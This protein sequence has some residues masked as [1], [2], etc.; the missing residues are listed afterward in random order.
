MTRICMT[1]FLLSGLLACRQAEE[2]VARVEEFLVYTSDRGEGF[3]LY[4]NRR[5]GSRERRLTKALD[6]STFPNF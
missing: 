1:I 2:P 3:D 5:D 6:G 4:R